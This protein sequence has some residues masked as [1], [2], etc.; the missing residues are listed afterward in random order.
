[1]KIKSRAIHKI[2]LGN[3]IENLKKYPNKFDLIIADP[4]FGINF[5]N[6]LGRRRSKINYIKYEDEF[7]DEE[8]IDFS[9]KWI[10]ACYNALK[11]N[12]SLYV[13]CAWGRVYEILHAV[14]MTNFD[15]RNHCIWA[16][17]QGMNCTR[18]YVTSHY[19]VIFLTKGKK[20]K[21]NWQKSSG[22]HEDVFFD[23]TYSRVADKDRIPEHP[24]QLPYWLLKHQILISSDYGDWI[25]DVFSGSGSTALA[26][27]RLG[28]NVISF[29][30]DE[31]Y[32]D[33]IKEK[34][35]WGKD[36]YLDP[37]AL[38]LDVFL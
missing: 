24:C 20:Y 37:D 2:E 14:R 23:P 4:P 33:V 22:Y 28:R 15:Y 19:H 11:K 18:R 6:R 17:K 29:E 16:F 13:Y 12:G 36:I 32:V 3:C 5:S 38:S 9:Y 27:R 10:D 1:M 26:C 30:K 34:T 8:Y 25:G 7:T 35:K 31:R 21:F